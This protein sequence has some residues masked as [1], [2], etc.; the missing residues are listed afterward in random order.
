MSSTNLKELYFEIE[1]YRFEAVNDFRYLGSELNTLNDIT[2]EI[3]NRL[4]A[5]NRCSHRLQKYLKSNSPSAEKL[6]YSCTNRR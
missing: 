1:E 5:G 6:H 4:T 3:R 2:P